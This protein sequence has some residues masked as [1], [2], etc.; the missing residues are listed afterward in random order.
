MIGT[1]IRADV[2]SIGGSM[3]A[4]TVGLFLAVW[5]G[6]GGVRAAQLAIDTVQDVP[7]RHRRSTLGSV[8]MAVVLLVVLAAYVMAGAAL[9]VV[10]TSG[11]GGIA[12][13]W[14][15]SAVLSVLLFAGAYRLLVSTSMPW[16]AT[17]PGACL[18][19]VAWTLL[20]VLGARIVSHQVASASD[21]YGTF[22]IVISASSHWIYL[23]AQVLLVGAVLNVVL[24]DRLWPRSFTG[25]QTEA[26]RRALTRSA[27]QEERVPRSASR[28]PS[29]RPPTDAAPKRE[30]ERT[31]GSCGSG[32]SP[33]EP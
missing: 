10:S 4:V 13:T 24:A 31:F 1:Q 7:R 9:G 15:A 6:I 17:I 12:L 20:L 8:A 33:T 21:V 14:G 30:R 32:G 18:A 27:R 11:P 19:G 26:D 3:V 2:G 5:A 29:S 23:G 25:T 28:S 22:A 16:S